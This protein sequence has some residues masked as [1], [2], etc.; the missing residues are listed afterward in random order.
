MAEHEQPQAEP[1]HGIAEIVRVPGVA[2]QATVEHLPGVGRVG[3]K[4][5]RLATPTASKPNP[6]AHTAAPSHETRPSGACSYIAACTGSD[7][8]HMTR[9][10]IQ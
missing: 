8:N 5:A 9:P 4:P 7:T 3:T 10:C 1:H 6:T 2:P